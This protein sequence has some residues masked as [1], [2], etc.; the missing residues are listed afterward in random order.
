MHCKLANRGQPAT[1]DGRF[2]A[3]SRVVAVEDDPDIRAVVDLALGNAGPLIS[4]CTIIRPSGERT[5]E[6]GWYNEMPAT[7]ATISKVITM[8]LFGKFIIT[9]L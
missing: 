2:R 4:S 3:L 5:P 6:S 7:A 1:D 8:I 9:V